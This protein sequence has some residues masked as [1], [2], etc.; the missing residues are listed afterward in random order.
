MRNRVG[1]WGDVGRI[2]KKFLTGFKPP[3]PKRAAVLKAL[4]EKPHLPEDLRRVAADAP[5]IIEDLRAAGH[6]IKSVLFCGHRRWVW[7][8][9]EGGRLCGVEGEK[10][11][12]RETAPK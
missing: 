11:K 9:A 2:D 1:D 3:N 10:G 6:V 5:E 7:C 8:L 12:D 4:R